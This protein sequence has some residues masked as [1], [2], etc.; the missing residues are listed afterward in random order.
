MLLS[1]INTTEKK[2]QTERQLIDRLN[3]IGLPNQIGDNFHYDHH[4]ILENL[5]TVKVFVLLG[6]QFHI[7]NN[8]ADDVDEIIFSNNS[9]QAR[10]LCSNFQSCSCSCIF[11]SLIHNFLHCIQ[12]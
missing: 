12:E 4:R 11:F 5:M 6:F 10:G 2:H 7:H 9:I 3:D 1:M 8:N